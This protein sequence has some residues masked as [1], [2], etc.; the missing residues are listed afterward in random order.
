MGNA[1]FICYQGFEWSRSLQFLSCGLPADLTGYGISFTVKNKAGGSTLIALTVGG[2][3]TVDLATATAALAMAAAQTAALSITGLPTLA[4]TEV[5][6]ID[7]CADGPLQS[8]TKIGP[9]AIFELVLTPPD[10]N[11]LPPYLIGS[12]LIYPPL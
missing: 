12:F 7:C 11:P 4:V 5:L 3:I 10:G 6:G 1:N 2:G 9:T 8:D